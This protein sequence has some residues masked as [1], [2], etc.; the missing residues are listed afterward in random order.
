VDGE[1]GPLVSPVAEDLRDMPAVMIHAGADELLVGDAE[2]M[3]DRLRAS[4]VPC[5]L[6]LW[7][8]QV[9]D[10]V[11]AGNATPESRRAIKTIGRFVQEVTT[12]CPSRPNRPATSTTALAA[13]S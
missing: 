13:A 10:F 5:D 4:G 12:H 2:M 3:A 7:A 6:H 11:V 1:P 9:H 8:G